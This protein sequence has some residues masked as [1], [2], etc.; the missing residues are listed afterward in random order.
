MH[1]RNHDAVQ[2]FGSEIFL[3]WL[4]TGQFITDARVGRNY[5]VSDRL[6]HNSLQHD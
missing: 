5:A 2:F 4:W 1:R 6:T 3:F